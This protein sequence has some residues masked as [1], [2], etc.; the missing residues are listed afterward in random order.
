MA[1]GLNK[2]LVSGATSNTASAYFQNQTF[3]VTSNS[4]AVL[5]S[6]T[7][8]VPASANISVEV[9]TVANTW[10]TMVA[11]AT[12]GLVISDGTNVRIRN[13]DTAANASLVLVTVNG[14]ANASGT[15][16]T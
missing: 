7:Y 2:I 8:Y 5:T 6:G 11:V 10:T 16:N 12:G 9:Q 3:A 1:L 14:G 13:A 15:Y 4:T